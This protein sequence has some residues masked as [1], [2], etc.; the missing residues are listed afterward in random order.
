MD[1]LCSFFLHC[2]RQNREPQGPPWL[3][4]RVALSRAT[5]HHLLIRGDLYVLGD[6]R[7]P[8]CPLTA[9]ETSHRKRAMGRQ[10]DQCLVMVREVSGEAPAPTTVSTVVVTTCGPSPSS[11]L[12]LEA[13]TRR[14]NDVSSG[15]Y[16]S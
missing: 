8:I 11:S 7:D 9:V 12:T 13:L 4:V 3:G 1:G 15:R 10:L 16:G 5:K 14:G 6:E 2:P